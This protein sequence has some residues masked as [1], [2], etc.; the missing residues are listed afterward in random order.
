M[1]LDIKRRASDCW[2]SDHDAGSISMGSHKSQKVL[3]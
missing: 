3:N 1:D 2:L